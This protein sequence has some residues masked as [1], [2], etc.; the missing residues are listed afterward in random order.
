MSASMAAMSGGLDPYVPRLLS[1]WPEEIPGHRL[2]E[3]T[4]LYADV[5]GFTRL[6]ERLARRG[7]S[8]AEEI[9][10]TISEIWRSLLS[11]TGDGDALKFAGD[12]LIVFFDGPDHEGR[13]CAAA[14]AMQ[15]ALAACASIRVG[16]GSVR[17]RMSVGVHAGRFHMMAVGDGQIELLILG[18]A[19][20]RTVT[21]E[22]A[23]SAGEVLTSRDTAARLDGRLQIRGERDGG[24]IVRE[25]RDVSPVE[26]AM[27]SSNGRL[28]RFVSPLL[29]DRLGSGIAFEHR[30]VTIGFCQIGG[31]DRML[32]NEGSE[33]V[34]EEMQRF[35][36]KLMGWID[37][38]GILLNSG[39]LAADGVVFMLVGGAPDSGDGDHA[40]R[41]MHLATQLL[42]DSGPL[43]IRMGINSGHV[44][45]GPVGPAQR[46][47]Y[48]TMGDT[49]N[50]AAR[51]MSNAGW[52]QVLV[53]ASSIDGDDRFVLREV[54][55]FQVKGKRRPVEA[56]AIESLTPSSETRSA[57]SGPF[58]GRDRELAVLHDALGAARAGRG[59]VVEIQGE[60]GVGKSRLIA[61][62]RAAVGETAWIAV[63]C[64]SFEHTT[65][66]RTARILVRQML[67]IE[68]ETTASEAGARLSAVVAEN[69]PHL[70]PWLPLL[71]VIVD[72]E[73]AETEE[74]RDVDP[75]F[76]R[77]KAQQ[78]M[79]D[80]MEAMGIASAVVSIE[81]AEH[82][83]DASAEL[84]SE[85]L[86]RI[87][88]RPWL[89]VITRAPSEEGLH[90]G[91]G[92]PATVIDLEPLDE[93]A[94]SELARR[95]AERSPVPPHLLAGIVNRA[96]GNPFFLSEMLAHAGAET[97]HSVEDIV[98]ARID[99]LA[100]S[101]R[102]ALRHLAVLGEKFDLG[103]VASV[104]GDRGVTP[105]DDELWRRL[106]G[107]VEVNESEVA[108][109]NPLVR[110]VAYDGL[111]YRIR[112]ELHGRVADS[113]GPGRAD[114]LA[115]HLVEAERWQDAWRA[116]RHAADRARDAAA[117][118]VAGE[119][120][121]LALRAADNVA[122]DDDE[123]SRVAE[124]AARV[125]ASAG[126]TDR[127]LQALA[128]AIARTADPI[129]R[130]ELEALRASLHEDAGRYPQA[131]R[132]FA[133]SLSRL[134]EIDAPG[135][136]RARAALHAG[137]AST[138]LR[139]GRHDEAQ[140]H[141]E[142]AVTSAERAGDRQSQAR[143]L[144]LLDRIHAAAGDFERAQH[145]RDEALPI[146]AE[147]GDLAAQGTALHDLAADAQR[148][149][150]LAEAVWLYQRA[151]ESRSRAGDVVQ[152]A[153]TINSLGE[154]EAALGMSDSA[155]QRFTE[156]L[157]TWRGARA[158]QGVAQATTNLGE[159]RIT[160]GLTEEAIELLE[161]AERLALDLGL[162]DVQ[163][164]GQVA[165]A[166][167]YQS[168]ERHVE[169]WE[170]A[171]AALQLGIAAPLAS[172]AR[173]IRAT[174]LEATGSKKRAEEERELA[175][176][177]ERDENQ[178]S[179]DG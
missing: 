110:Q 37:A 88:E 165:L 53:T 66:Y 176:S 34:F 74:S 14:L 51:V 95:L 130:L 147:L 112:R 124:D 20:T 170:R 118:S 73:V 155:E 121:E 29:R 16:K 150:R 86:G 58:L 31:V 50:L 123:V 136:E 177:L 4:L 52:G 3:G 114:Q 160:Q 32:A 98:A 157:R 83:D 82:M 90:Q 174:A 131:L 87:D 30:R 60:Q 159:L 92:Y 167:A 141:A 152:A 146:F 116:A 119:L 91:R 129:E 104:L 163:A 105:D 49:A 41:M 33:A 128:V 80:L 142:A 22:E 15:E 63:R 175:L 21:T 107:F 135:R 42:G 108:F 115:L 64:D 166:Q 171:T 24:V 9:V 19:A 36:S 127:A 169:A 117:N 106:A 10:T 1:G 54:P 78:V 101:D 12:A 8:G 164:R 109:A 93:T 7:R 125:W 122:I 178:S 47:A 2:V 161:E 13:A 139:Q 68:R 28:D 149:G 26:Q 76:R 172:R 23:A 5:S 103:L 120:Y 144:H 48:V 143:A 77:V 17:L 65:P 70:L 179:S 111:P 38:A 27:S 156:A 67:G 69:A 46:R 55:P 158:P 97:P 134:D 79:A 126:M 81:D 56:M 173:S 59:R 151:A 148:S 96:A 84:V 35:V 61:E 43:Q 62:F 11:V 138:R 6:S 75:R 18:E 89:V 40:I 44:F 154:V 45:A 168:V 71:A 99:A 153:A 137:Y 162:E 57:S 113:L 39:D 132:L 145:Y 133:T 140:H 85:L 25:V 100:P 102:N 94:A 72:G